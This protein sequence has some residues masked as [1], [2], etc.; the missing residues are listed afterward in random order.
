MAYNSLLPLRPTNVVHQLAPEHPLPLLSGRLCF[1]SQAL[2]NMIIWAPA[3]DH[4]AVIR[5]LSRAATHLKAVVGYCFAPTKTDLLELKP[6]AHPASFFQ[7]VVE[8][9]SALNYRVPPFF[10]HIQEPP[11]GP[12]QMFTFEAVRKH[13][14]VS[15]DC[16][17]TSFGIDFSNCPEPDLLTAMGGL[18]G[19]ILELE[20]ALVVRLPT[21]ITTGP[22]CIAKV[23][24][25]IKRLTNAGVMPDLVQIDSDDPSRLKE[26]SMAI[27][28]VGIACNEIRQHSSSGPLVSAGLR[29]MLADSRLAAL[30]NR[31][32]HD[33][34]RLEALAY[35]EATDWIEKLGG[36]G[37]ADRLTANL[38][39][40]VRQ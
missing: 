12:T 22:E 34:E 35:L 4:P 25:T 20:L 17:F 18:V 32:R 1:S 27:T 26:L 40:M 19:Q 5:A 39:D 29:A 21:V 37:S 10:L 33:P 15:L 24:Q 30:V 9:A 23:V 3:I 7:A 28:P 38:S 14:N 8:S 13:L 36:R 6:T 16:G 2:R 11:V 31:Y